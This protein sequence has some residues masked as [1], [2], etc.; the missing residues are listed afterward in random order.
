[1]ASNNLVVT[2][3]KRKTLL[4][5]GPARKKTVARKSKGGSK[6]LRELY[7]GQAKKNKQAPQEKAIPDPVVEME[8]TKAIDELNLDHKKQG[9]PFVPAV[10]KSNEARN[11]Q[12]SR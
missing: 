11:G 5:I 3:K 9:E 6:R 7:L 12:H 10:S 1:M 2:L 4:T 8:L